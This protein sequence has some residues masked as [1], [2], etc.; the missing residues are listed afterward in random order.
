M[1]SVSGEAWEKVGMVGGATGFPK[2][3]PLTGGAT[4]HWT[5][6][7]DLLDLTEAPCFRMV[8]VRSDCFP[9]TFMPCPRPSSCW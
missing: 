7:R 3:E 2:L 1:R 4:G 9:E 6:S 8:P 5:G